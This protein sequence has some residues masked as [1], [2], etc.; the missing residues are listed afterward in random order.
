MDIRKYEVREEREVYGND[1]R[2]INRH[3]VRCYLVPGHDYKICLDKTL[4]G[5]PQFYEL[6]SCEKSSD[7]ILVGGR[8]CFGEGLNWNQAVKLAGEAIEQRF[9][10]A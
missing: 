4:D 8:R 3:S 7:Y 1:D 5:V 2:A 6:Y 9:Q 10:E